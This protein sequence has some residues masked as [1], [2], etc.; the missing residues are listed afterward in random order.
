VVVL[1]EAG[2]VA[3]KLN[4]MIRL[5]WLHVSNRSCWAYCSG[6]TVGYNLGLRAGTTIAT[7]L[8][9]VV[10]ALTEGPKSID[11]WPLRRVAREAIVG[12]RPESVVNRRTIPPRPS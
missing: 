2:R 9:K 6:Y 4:F 8:V 7:A 3:Y 5:Y 11:S 10:I 1:Y 12:T